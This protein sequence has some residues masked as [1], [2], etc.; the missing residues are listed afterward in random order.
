AAA[1][2][3]D[4][5]VRADEGAGVLV[6]PEADRER[7]VRERRQQPAQPVALAEV[8]V[9]HH[10]VAQAQPRC[11][12]DA[13]GARRGV[14]AVAAG[15]HV[16]AEDAGAGTGA[17]DGDAL[18]VGGADRLRH[19]GAA[20]DGGQ[21]QLVAAG[22]EDAAGLFDLLHAVA[23]AGVAAGVEIEHADLARAHLGEQ[24]LVAVAGVVEPAGGRDHRDLGTLAPAQLEEPLQHAHVA[25]LVLGTTD[26]NDPAAFA[27][28]GHPAGTHAL[29]TPLLSKRSALEHT[30]A[31]HGAI[32]H[33][34]DASSPHVGDAAVGI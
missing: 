17:A 27:A 3:L 13:V 25:L 21:P 24:L 8:L 20:E 1:F 22:D 10:P 9:D 11:E 2:D 14:V 19:R 7:V 6:H 31:F 15:D 33:V 26:G 4:H 29:D 30:T 16:R 18:R 5:V 34:G 28:I 32:A 12:A 23:F